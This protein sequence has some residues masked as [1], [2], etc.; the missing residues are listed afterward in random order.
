MIFFPPCFY[1]DSWREPKSLL[2]IK[3]TGAK[4]DSSWSS[5]GSKNWGYDKLGPQG[6]ETFANRASI[7]K[8]RLCCDM[9][10]VCL[11]FKI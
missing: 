3:K 11:L 8:A 5:G 4:W 6:P 2:S 10:C 1:L 7:N 9:T